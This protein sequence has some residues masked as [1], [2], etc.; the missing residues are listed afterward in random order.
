MRDV[1]A[2]LTVRVE[3]DE[4]YGVGSWRTAGDGSEGPDET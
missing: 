2:G 4:V 3:V 1:P